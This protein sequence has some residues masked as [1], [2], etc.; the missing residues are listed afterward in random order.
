M[1]KKKTDAKTKLTLVGIL[2]VVSSFLIGF[3][4]ADIADIIS[5]VSL[6]AGIALMLIAYKFKK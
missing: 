1:S 2:L 6:I 5:L 4:P 3:I